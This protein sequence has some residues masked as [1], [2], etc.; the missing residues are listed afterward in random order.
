[1]SVDAVILLALGIGVG[2]TIEERGA[3]RA[4][5]VGVTTMEAGSV[6]AVKPIM[7]FNTKR[8]DTSYG[9]LW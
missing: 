2:Q 4:T 8:E 3:V 6:N 1:L 7:R 5:A 9:A